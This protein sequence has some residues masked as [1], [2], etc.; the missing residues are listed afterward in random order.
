MP[1][2]GNLAEGSR[3]AE[4]TK[5]SYEVG[6]VKKKK[7]SL[8]SWDAKRVLLTK[9]FG[10]LWSDI[11]S[12]RLVLERKEGTRG[13]KGCGGRQQHGSQPGE[14]RALP[15]S[16]SAPALMAAGRR[17]GGRSLG[18]SMSLRKPWG[19]LG[20]GVPCVSVLLFGGSGGGGKMAAHGGSAAASALK[21]LIQQFTAITGKRRGYRKVESGVWSGRPV[22]PG[23]LF[24]FM[25]SSLGLYPQ[26]PSSLLRKK[27]RLRRVSGFRRET[28]PHPRA[29][30]TFI[31]GLLAVWR[32]ISPP[33]F[34]LDSGNGPSLSAPA[35]PGTWGRERWGAAPGPPPSSFIIISSSLCS[36][37]VQRIPSPLF[38]FL[39]WPGHSSP[40]PG[41]PFPFLGPSEPS[42]WPWRVRALPP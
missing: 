37:G 30:H 12:M 39:P 17:G 8:W 15:P 4:T 19:E 41:L 36:L 42:L 34:S 24:T 3:V 18:W 11:A 38:P 10:N 20:E 14:P 27:R 32:E 22:C 29:P 33:P 31:L 23:L 9:T 13:R 16:G 5:Q 1:V 21:G 7:K 40:V 25:H 26:L 2:A 35:G 6:S 28:P